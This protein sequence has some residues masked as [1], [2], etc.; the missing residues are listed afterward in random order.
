ML[1]N[2]SSRGMFILSEGFRALG[3]LGEDFGGPGTGGDGGLS[4]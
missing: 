1:K 4:A 3:Y 2:L